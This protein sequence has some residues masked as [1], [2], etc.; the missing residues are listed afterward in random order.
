M[1]FIGTTNVDCPALPKSGSNRPGDLLHSRLLYG[2]SRFDGRY[3][4]QEAAQQVGSGDNAP[5]RAPDQDQIVV[6]DI[7]VRPLRRNF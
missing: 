4:S 2:A 6:D 3:A 5:L 1:C 7:V